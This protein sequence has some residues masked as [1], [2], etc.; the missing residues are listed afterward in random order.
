MKLETRLCKYAF[1]IGLAI[2]FIVTVW[3]AW[4]LYT[5]LIEGM[6]AS[7]LV[8][9]LGSWHVA[10]GVEFITFFAATVCLQYLGARIPPV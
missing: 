1:W 8:E 4:V 6:L 5:A 2:L 10:Y 7:T 9:L 3:Y